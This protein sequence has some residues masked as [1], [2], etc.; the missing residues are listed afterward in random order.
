MFHQINHKRVAVAL[1]GGVDSSVAA[2]LLLEQGFAVWGVHL[3]LAPGAPRPEHL[4]ALGARL[5]IPITEIDLKDAFAREVLD[6]FIREYSRGRTPNPCVRCNALIKFGALWARVREA[7]A[8]FLATGHYARVLAGPGGRPGLYRGLDRMKDQSYFLSRLSPEVL[9]HLLFPLGELTKA[10][11]RRR[12]QELGLPAAP[13]CRESVEL[14]FLPQGHHQEFI[15]AQL[16]RPGPPGDLLDTAGRVLGRHRGLERYTVG[17]RRGLGVP[18]REPYYVVEI[19]PETNQVVLGYREELFAA[20]LMAR[21]VNWLTDPP[22]QDFT[23]RAVIRYRHSGVPALLR[24]L[25]H[26]EVEVIFET[27]QAAVAPGQA[28]VFYQDDLVLGGG[29]IEARLK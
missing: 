10:E 4:T 20:G 27:P 23:A 9:P 12:H 16:G 3:R 24:P 28:V 21:Q 25:E 13:G 7:G 1:S 15:A 19:R 6:Y 14:C 22:R 17:Q 8:A 18:A 26:G 29:W 5:K 2:A 11:V